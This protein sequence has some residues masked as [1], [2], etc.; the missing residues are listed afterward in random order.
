MAVDPARPERL[1]S[2]GRTAPLVGPGR[3][4]ASFSPWCPSDCPPPLGLPT[5]TGGLVEDVVLCG[6][7]RVS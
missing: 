5:G 3:K 7:D 1:Y 6:Q 2:V 4:A